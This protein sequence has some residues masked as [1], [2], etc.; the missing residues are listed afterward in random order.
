METFAE[1][2]MY[3][4]RDDWQERKVRNPSRFTQEK[5]AKKMHISR[6]Q[7]AT[8]LAD[9]KDPTVSFISTYAIAVGMKPSE[10]MERIAEKI[11]D[12]MEMRLVAQI[13]ERVRKHKTYSKKQPDIVST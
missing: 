6:S 2:A 9:P 3:V 13:D 10:L 12:E 11:D 1:L 8:S 7:F 5:I 4:I